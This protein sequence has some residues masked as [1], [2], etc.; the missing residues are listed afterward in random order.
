M[1][2]ENKWSKWWWDKSEWFMDNVG[3]PLL[4]IFFIICIIG[5]VVAVL[6]K[7]NKEPYPLFHHNHPAIIRVEE[8]TRLQL[9]TVKPMIFTPITE[10]YVI[11]D[12]RYY[13]NCEA[14]HNIEWEWCG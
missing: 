8:R 2:H 9:I 11:L 12:A 14:C 7:H 5:L 3:L 10:R 4:T 6:P 1:D 13:M